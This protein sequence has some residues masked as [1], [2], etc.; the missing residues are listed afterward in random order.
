MS[1]VSTYLSS[2][3]VKEKRAVKP[4]MVYTRIAEMVLA[5]QWGSM[6]HQPLSCSSAPFLERWLRHHRP[7]SGKGH[8]GQK[9]EGARLCVPQ[10]EQDLFYVTFV[11]TYACY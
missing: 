3:K 11:T 6:S 10:M 4:M 2:L 9:A 8:S 5:R 7:S 1:S